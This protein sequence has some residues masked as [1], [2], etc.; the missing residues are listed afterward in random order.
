MIINDG[1]RC[2]F[3]KCLLWEDKCIEESISGKHLLSFGK[4][5]YRCIF[6]IN[7]HSI[8]NASLGKRKGK[9]E[10]RHAVGM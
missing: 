5:L 7:K 10:S 1:C 6:N 8:R 4:E 3:T 2:F 9:S